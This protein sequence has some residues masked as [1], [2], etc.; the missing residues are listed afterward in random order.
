MYI[1]EREKPLQANVTKNHSLRDKNAFAAPL[2]VCK[3][4][5]T[6]FQSTI[7]LSVL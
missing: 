2:S 1:G 5:D 4:T 3:Q 7:E 6:D